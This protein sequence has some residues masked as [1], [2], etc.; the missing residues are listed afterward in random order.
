MGS[1]YPTLDIDFS[2]VAVTNHPG[3]DGPKDLLMNQEALNA[4]A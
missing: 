1:W 2:P 4:P 3:D